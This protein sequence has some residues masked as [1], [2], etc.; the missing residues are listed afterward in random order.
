MDQIKGGVG[1][2]V[3][4]IDPEAPVG[5]VAQR[6]TEPFHGILFEGRNNSTDVGE[7]EAPAFFSDLNLDQVIGS[8]T[9]GRDEYNLKPFFYEPLTSLQAIRYR[10]EIL[11][12]LEGSGLFKHVG[13][14][15]Q[16]MRSMREHLV[17]AGKLY[18]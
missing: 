6:M 13:N 14:F 7:R 10:H 3:R 2:E 4:T 9:S 11:R 17:Q 15:A 8:I 1:Q 18:L 16:K 5:E 12:D